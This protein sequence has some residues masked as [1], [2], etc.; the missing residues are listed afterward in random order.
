MKF[1]KLVLYYYDSCPYCQLVMRA[2]TKIDLIME[3]K[4]T[5]QDQNNRAY[6]VQRTGRSTVPCLFIDDVPMHESR[7]IVDWL[8]ENENRLEKKP[9]A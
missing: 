7:D 4:N 9:K 5:Q 8:D 3:Y 1:P 2:I 6:L